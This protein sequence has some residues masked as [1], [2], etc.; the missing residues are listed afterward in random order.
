MCFFALIKRIGTTK[1]TYTTLISP[2][3]AMLASS[4]F[5]EYKWTYLTFLGLA[6]IVGS[7]LVLNTKPK[8]VQAN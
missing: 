5:E 6:M 3:L 8:S 1:A 2:V 4:V 7:K